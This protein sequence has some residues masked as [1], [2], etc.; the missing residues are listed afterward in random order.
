VAAGAAGAGTPPATMH[1]ASSATMP[2]HTHSTIM[3]RCTL[4]PHNEPPHAQPTAQLVPNSTSAPAVSNP[5]R[6]PVHHRD[7]GFHS[8]IGGR[9]ATDWAALGLR[10][11]PVALGCPMS[12][13]AAAAADALARTNTAEAAEEAGAAAPA[14]AVEAAAAA[15][16][17][18]DARRRVAR[19]HLECS[20][21]HRDSLCDWTVSQMR[22]VIAKNPHSLT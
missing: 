10:Q 7:G 21:A 19:A 8:S 6:L 3:Q 20:M 16:A 11:S 9:P 13:Q 14:G 1:T 12:T 2:S 17:A 18:A 22:A 15:V 4:G 5:A